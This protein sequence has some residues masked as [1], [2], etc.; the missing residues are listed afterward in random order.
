MGGYGRFLYV[1]FYWNG[2][3]HGQLT[4]ALQNDRRQPTTPTP[5]LKK[6]ADTL[7]PPSFFTFLVLNTCC[8]SYGLLPRPAIPITRD[9]LL[10][11]L[12]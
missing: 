1:I 7:Q 8:C 5:D 12:T 4:G 3:N 10:P 2:E 9:V 11:Q 6:T